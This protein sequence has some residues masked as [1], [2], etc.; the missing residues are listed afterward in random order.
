MVFHESGIL[1][2][3]LGAVILLPG[4][5]YV[6]VR[7]LIVPS[8]RRD[9]SKS[10]VEFLG[11]SAVNYVI[12]AWPLLAS[13]TRWRALEFHW[14]DYVALL[15]ITILFPAAAAVTQIRASGLNLLDRLA[16]T[17]LSTRSVEPTAW[18]FFFA[19][20]SD[21][22]WILVRLRNGTSVAGIYGNQS[23]ASRYPSPPSLYLE[24]AYRLEEDRV[25]DAPDDS[26]GLIIHGEDIHLLEFWDMRTEDKRTPHD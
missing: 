5:V 1:A 26:A 25:M 14:S 16:G 23:Y 24:T 3:L 7:E 9:F 20:R 4:F 13:L 10:V 22:C 12:F 8:P 19:R 15:I 21:P 11:Y 2:F 17:G 6:Q 18:D